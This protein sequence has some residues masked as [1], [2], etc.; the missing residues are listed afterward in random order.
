MAVV[1]T[2]KATGPAQIIDIRAFVC[3]ILNSLASG[4]FASFIGPIIYSLRVAFGCLSTSGRA[5]FGGPP[6]GPGRD[7]RERSLGGR[8]GP[9][10]GSHASAESRGN[11]GRLLAVTVVVVRDRS[12]R[13]LVDGDAEDP[14]VGVR[15]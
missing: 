1:S 12:A 10:S 6:P 11:L 14:H 8:R 13:D 5:R 4:P 2:S 3:P 7:R 15:Q 9:D